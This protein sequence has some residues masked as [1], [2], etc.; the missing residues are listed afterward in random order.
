MCVP[1]QH[2]YCLFHFQQ[3]AIPIYAQC[4]LRS[5]LAVF[6]MKNKPPTAEPVNSDRPPCP[7]RA[8]AALLVRSLPFPFHYSSSTKTPGVASKAVSP[9]AACWFS[10]NLLGP[11]FFYVFLFPLF[12]PSIVS[13]CCT[14]CH[15]ISCRLSWWLSC[16]RSFFGWLFWT[17]R[18]VSHSKKDFGY[19]R[20][21]IIFVVFSS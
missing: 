11:H 15:L 14:R 2:I 7:D 8:V 19:G 12:L 17:F 9:S 21:S 3:I 4:S 20:L 16:L 10:N 18:W 5:G 1:F 13:F 6:Q